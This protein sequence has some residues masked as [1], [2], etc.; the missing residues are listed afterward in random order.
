MPSPRL[1][2]RDFLKTGGKAVGTA[3]VGSAVLSTVGAPGMLSSAA[4][5][6]DDMPAHPEGYEAQIESLLANGELVITPVRGGNPPKAVVPVDFPHGW[7]F[8]PGDVMWT[9]F[10]D[11]SKAWPLV[12]SFEID[13]KDLAPVLSDPGRSF[14]LAGKP[15]TAQVATVHEDPLDSGSYVCWR[16]PNV[17]SPG[18]QMI[19]AR[20]IVR[21]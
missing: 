15:T 3:V 16:V 11:D 7:I 1:S 4:P 2:R 12:E 20:P 19:A 10:P 21:S 13:S 9:R 14:V 17:S 8:H 6:E 5:A 18:L